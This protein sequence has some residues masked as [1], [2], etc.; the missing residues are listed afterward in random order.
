ADPDPDSSALCCS[1]DNSCGSPP[2][3]VI[4]GTFGFPLMGAEI[5]ILGARVSS[6]GNFANRDLRLRCFGGLASASSGVVTTSLARVTR[7]A[8]L[9]VERSGW[10]VVAWLLPL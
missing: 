4:L 10:T 6:F 5:T 9:A 7:S 3:W 2:S 1:S 8:F